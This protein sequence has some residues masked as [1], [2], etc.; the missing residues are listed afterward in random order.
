MALTP[1]REQY[2]R[3]LRWHGKLSRFRD[4]VPVPEIKISKQLTAELLRLIE[5]APRNAEGKI[6]LLDVALP[7]PLGKELNDAFAAV[8]NFDELHDL[9]QIF[10]QQCFHL[11]DWIRHDTGGAKAAQAVEAFVAGS[12]VLEA[13]RDICNGSKHLSLWAPRV[14]PTINAKQ[15]LATS[16]GGRQFLTATPTVDVRGTRYGLFDLAN[17]CVDEWRGFLDQHGI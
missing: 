12:P 7:P 16:T 8:M 11:K 3:M 1:A 15:I 17:A 2:E 4:G 5:A 14:A 10:F 9:A 13:A 6:P